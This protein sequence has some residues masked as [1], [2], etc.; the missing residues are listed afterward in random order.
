M[1]QVETCICRDDLRLNAAPGTEHEYEKYNKMLLD[2][3]EV[4]RERF[5]SFSMRFVYNRLE[6]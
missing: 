3:I 6:L 5:F 4:F 1:C 2:R